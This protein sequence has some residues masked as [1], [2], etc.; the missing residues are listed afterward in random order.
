MN[1]RELV[2]CFW[3]QHDQKQSQYRSAVYDFHAERTKAA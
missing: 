3:E 2:A 1:N